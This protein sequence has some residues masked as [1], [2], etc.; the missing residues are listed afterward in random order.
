VILANM[1]VYGLIEPKTIGSFL[2]LTD[3]NKSQSSDFLPPVLRLLTASNF[4]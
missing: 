1:R 3:A 2:W 4:L